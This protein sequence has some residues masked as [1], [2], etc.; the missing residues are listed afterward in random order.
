MAYYGRRRMHVIFGDS[1]VNDDLYKQIDTKNVSKIP[2][3]IE[4][5]KGAGLVEVVEKAD[6]Y[7]KSY[8]FD[9]VYIVA[10]V[11]DITNKDR[12]SGRISFLWKSEDALATYLI[13]VRK[14]SYE[15][16]KKDH[17]GA[18]VVFC[19]LIGMDLH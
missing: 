15:Q 1:R 4:Q 3:N 13:E 11:N 9:I 6:I 12:A 17:L 16:L 7:L 10:G 18:G 14:R 5:Y 19:P 8:P 2:F